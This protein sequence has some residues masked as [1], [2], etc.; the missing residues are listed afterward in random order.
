ML[1]KGKTLSIP[2]AIF[3]LSSLYEGHSISNAILS[4]IFTLIT[5]LKFDLVFLKH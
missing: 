2:F 1:I 3:I 4:I 5:L